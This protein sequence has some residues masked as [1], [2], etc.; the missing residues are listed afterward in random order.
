[1]DLECDNSNLSHPIGLF[2]IFKC[3]QCK[4]IQ[5]VIE[6][7]NKCWCTILFL[8]LVHKDKSIFNFSFESHP[9]WELVLTLKLDHTLPFHCWHPKLRSITKV[10]VLTPALYAS[11]Y[12]IFIINPMNFLWSATHTPAAVLGHCQSF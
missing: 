8:L 3:G 10:L 12:S 6:W 5:G 9:Y 7:L 4:Q 11:S 2:C 1:M